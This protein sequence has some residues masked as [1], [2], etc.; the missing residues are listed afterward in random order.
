MNLRDN[1]GVTGIDLSVALVII[2]VFV[3]II[4]TLVYNFGIS[5]KGVNRTAIATN[6]L[7][8]KIEELKQQDYSN[9]QGTT[10]E[11]K[12]ENGI[13]QGS[14]PYKVTT[15]ITKYA[16][17]NYVENLNSV[18]KEQLLDV[19]KIAKVTVEYKVGDK[20]EKID[21]STAITKEN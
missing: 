15:E 8:K 18:E 3:G 13:T 21:I 7:I 6:I 2:V 1:K 12:D 4:A 5:S 16:D 20:N 14:A 17:S 19:I 11:Y 9:L 10:I